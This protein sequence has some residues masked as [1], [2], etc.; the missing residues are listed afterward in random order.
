MSNQATEFAPLLCP[1]KGIRWSPCIKMCYKISHHHMTMFAMGQPGKTS[2]RR[3]E[4]IESNM[5][6]VEVYYNTSTGAKLDLIHSYLLNDV[7][8]GC[9]IANIVI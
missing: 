8:S 9:P 7:L 1:F 4:C 6:P 2:L 3:Y 5:V